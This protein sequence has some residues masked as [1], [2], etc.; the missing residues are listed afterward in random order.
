M[1]SNCGKRSVDFDP[2][3]KGVQ[4]L[5]RRIAVRVFPLLTHWVKPQILFVC[6]HP[7]QYPSL[8]GV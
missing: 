3:A 2:S 6:S 4:L 1:P 5:Q 8:I 7:V